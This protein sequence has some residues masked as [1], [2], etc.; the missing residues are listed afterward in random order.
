M[1]SER[2]LTVQFLP[3]AAESLVVSVVLQENA[4]L[5][6]VAGWVRVLRISKTCRTRSQRIKVLLLETL[7]IMT[8]PLH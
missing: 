3:T 1:P 8:D 2:E 4:G 7:L 5:E 6:E